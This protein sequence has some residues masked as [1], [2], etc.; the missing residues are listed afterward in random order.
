MGIGAKM[1]KPVCYFGQDCKC[2]EVESLL[3]LYESK[4]EFREMNKLRELEHKLTK[5]DLDRPDRSEVWLIASLA[6]LGTIVFLLVCCAVFKN[7]LS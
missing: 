2:S 4:A 3:K 7:I 1:A 5:S 6:S